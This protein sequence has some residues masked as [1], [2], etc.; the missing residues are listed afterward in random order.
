MHA[1]NERIDPITPSPQE[2]GERLLIRRR[3]RALS[4]QELADRA[5]VSKLTVGRIERAEFTGVPQGSTTRKI[6]AAL[7][8]SP[9]WLLFGDV[10]EHG[11]D[12][13][14]RQAAA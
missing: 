2:I 6:A 4:Q 1:T 5:G 14:V 8:V 9:E 10:D 12:G 13:G 7:G 11:N 3:R